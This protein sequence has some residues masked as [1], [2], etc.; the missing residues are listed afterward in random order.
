MGSDTADEWLEHLDL[1]WL[2]DD[3]AIDALIGDVSVLQAVEESSS[4][5][6]AA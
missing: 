3:E 1:D 6:P 4:D 5:E 2:E